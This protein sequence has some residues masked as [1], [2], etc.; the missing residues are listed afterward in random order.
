MDIELKFNII[1]AFCLQVELTK[2]NKKRKKRKLD[3]RKCCNILEVE[4]TVAHNYAK[5][6]YYA[7][8]FIFLALL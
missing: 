4:R 7:H 3:K 5:Y 2:T 1:E 6:R 8:S